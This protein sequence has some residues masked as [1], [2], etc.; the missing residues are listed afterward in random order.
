[1]PAAVIILRYRAVPQICGAAFVC[2]CINVIILRQKL[3][4]KTVLITDDDTLTVYATQL[5]SV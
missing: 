1:M 5:T 2:T 3:N 4:R